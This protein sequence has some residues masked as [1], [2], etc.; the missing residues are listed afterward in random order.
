MPNHNKNNHQRISIF[1]IINPGTVYIALFLYTAI[2]A[3][4][5]R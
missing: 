1:A 4:A 3:L 2:C 5:A